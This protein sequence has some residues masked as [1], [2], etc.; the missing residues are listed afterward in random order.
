[1]DDNYWGDTGDNGE[2]DSYGG[3][4]YEDWQNT[5]TLGVDYFENKLEPGGG[6]VFGAHNTQHITAN[7]KAYAFWWILARMAGWD[8]NPFTLVDSINVSSA[9]GVTEIF[10]GETLQLSAEV[11]PDSSTEKGVSWSVVNQTGSAT[12][13][14]DGLLTAT[15]IGTVD[16]VAAAMDSSGV[17]DS[18]HLTIAAPLILVNSIN[19]SSAGGVTEVLNGETLQFSAVVLPENAAV[20]GISWSVTDQTGSGTITQDGLF[21]ATG[22]GTVDIVATAMDGSGVTGTMQI[23]IAD[24]KILVNSISISSAG[25]V[26]EILNGVTLQFSAEIL[27]EDAT[28]KDITWSV[29]NQTGSGTITQDGLFSATG[30]GIVDIVVTANDG[31]GVSTSMTIEILDNMTGLEDLKS[32]LYPIYPNPGAGVFFLNTTTRKVDFLQIIDQNGSIVL[33]LIPT[34]GSPL[35]EIDITAH[36]SGE[37]YVRLFSGQK[38]VVES[39]ILL[40]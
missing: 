22:V 29:T 34:P 18:L 25:G 39:V 37:Y 24:P 36:P 28:V 3:N 14:P 12:I 16:I 33:D 6:V 13:T 21:S 17:A 7:R 20:K 4:F 32:F 40:K 8:G 27:P 15:G 2:S 35:I 9:G 11:L 30:L 1:M 23:T 31:S 26:T 38:S 10:N 5:H 19:V